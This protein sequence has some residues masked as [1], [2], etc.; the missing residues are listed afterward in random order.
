MRSIF[1]ENE[2]EA[3]EEEEYVDVEVP[4]DLKTP[5]DEDTTVTGE[6]LHHINLQGLISPICPLAIGWGLFGTYGIA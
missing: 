4:D 5:E 6:H 3:E 2:A 1:D